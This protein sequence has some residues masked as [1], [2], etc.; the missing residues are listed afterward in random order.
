MTTG[1]ASEVARRRERRRVL[2]VAGLP[3]PE[4]LAEAARQSPLWAEHESGDLVL[5][6]PAGSAP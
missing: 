1:G 4:E 3:D 2:A 5:G 6:I